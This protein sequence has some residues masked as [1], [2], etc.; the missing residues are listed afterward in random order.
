MSDLMEQP[1]D[2][3]NPRIPRINAEIKKDEKNIFFIIRGFGTGS[4]LIGNTMD[5]SN[6]FK[7]N[8]SQ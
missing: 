7:F 8:K 5:E 1:E 6:L 3:S 4:T 2:S